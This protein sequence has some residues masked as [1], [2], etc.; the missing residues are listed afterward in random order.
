MEIRFIVCAGRSEMYEMAGGK[1][2][3]WKEWRGARTRARQERGVIWLIQGVG[4]QLSV[5]SVE[6]DSMVKP[7]IFE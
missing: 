1:N 6:D 4:I 5:Q 2:G 7:W 3:V